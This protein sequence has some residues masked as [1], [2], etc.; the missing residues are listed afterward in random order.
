LGEI[1]AALYAHPAV[2]EAVVL[3]REDGRD[4]KSLV[5]Y[6]VLQGA[7]KPS[8]N[9]L[10]A[11]LKKQLPDYMVPARFVVL[12]QLPLTPNGKVDRKQLFD[13]Q[14]TTLVGEY[15]ATTT[16][17]ESRLV[18]IWAELLKLDPKTIS[19]SA[20]FFE[21]GGH[22]LL[23]VRLVD[24]IAA[25]WNVELQ[26]RDVFETPQLAS[27]ALAIESSKNQSVRARIVA[28]ARE[29]NE[30]LASYAQQRLWFIDQLAGGSPQ[31]NMPG[32]LR[33]HGRFSEDIAERALRQIIERHEPL[34]TVFLNSTA[35]PLQ[36][37]HEHFDFQL[38]RL[39]LSGLN[40]EQQE[41]RVREA[42]EADAIKPF[43]LST[44]LKLRASFLRLSEDEGV[45][46]FNVHHIASDGWSMGILVNEFSTLYEAFSQGQPDPLPPLEVQYA[47]YAEWQ[48]ECLSG[49]VL[50]RQMRYWEHQLAELPQVHGLPLDRPRPADRK[51]TRLNSS[52]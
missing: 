6:L 40:S 11:A 13:C 12:E 28:R 49:E 41:Q 18:R 29:T 48:R 42:A 27:L 10:R 37:I 38:Q 9:E 32:S 30:L 19:A 45:L 4:E 44:D 14:G 25:E 39:E 33:I 23:C 8:N 1:E 35:G 16:A 3:V 20:N 2:R 31:Y 36:H 21:L 52:H 22:S 15:L 5:A 43:D 47:D 51:S 34:R 24:Q 50:E 17:T 26:V 7:E 46:L